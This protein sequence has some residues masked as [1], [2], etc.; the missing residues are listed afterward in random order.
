[1][2]VR[3]YESQDSKDVVAMAQK[4]A[5]WDATPTEADVAGFWSSEPD[6]FLVAELEGRVVGFVFGRESRDM[7]ME[8]LTKRHAT[9]AGYIETLAVTQE[10][11]RKGIGTLLLNSLFERLR[12]RGVDYVSLHVPAE[13]TGAIRLYEKLGFKTRGY[14]LNRK[15]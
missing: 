4:Y 9:K 3:K 10:H 5:S 13:E 12:R 15:L 8:V 6:L 11:R 2:T 14:H 1:M 7:P